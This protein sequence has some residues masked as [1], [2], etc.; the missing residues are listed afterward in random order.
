MQEA[1]TGGGE[2]SRRTPNDDPPCVRILRARGATKQQQWL[3][4]RNR[5][6]ELLRLEFAYRHAVNRLRV[7]GRG[8]NANF[9]DTWADDVV[10]EAEK[11]S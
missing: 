5:D 6:A 10:A 9:L 1:E 2:V 8:M 4:T 7:L 3:A 11:G